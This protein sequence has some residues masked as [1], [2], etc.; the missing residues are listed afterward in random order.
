MERLQKY[1]DV[2][3]AGKYYKDAII[4]NKKNTV[5]SII[6]AAPMAG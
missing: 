3:L 5:K 4:S 6:F 2:L 1:F